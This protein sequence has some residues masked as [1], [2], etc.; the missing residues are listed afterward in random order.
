M[1]KKLTEKAVL[2]VGADGA[3]ERMLK[4]YVNYITFDTNK[5]FSKNG[6]DDIDLVVF[7]GGEDVHP[8]LYGGSECGLSYT[9]IKRDLFESSLFNKCV[10]KGIKITGICRGFQ[11]INVMTGGK[12]Y[13]HI[14]GHAGVVHRIVFPALGVGYPVASTH[15]QLV[16]LPPTSIPMA[17]SIP[18]L[19]N[20]YK[21]LNGKESVCPIMETEAAVM[22]SFNTMGVQ[23]HPEF[24]NETH[25]S[26]TA[27]LHLLRDFINMGIHEFTKHYTSRDQ[28][29]QYKHYIYDPYKHC[30]IGDYHHDKKSNER[31][32][33]KYRVRRAAKAE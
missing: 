17:W 4:N 14:T 19:S 15:H 20:V 27:Y 25:R 10:R 23:Y 30:I 5:I 3:I 2:V 11:F 16:E 6:L 22:P 31:A 8:D 1:L 18:R 12:M 26:R 33:N 32:G 9:N 21:D 28:Y 24:M 29:D 7:T 13:Q